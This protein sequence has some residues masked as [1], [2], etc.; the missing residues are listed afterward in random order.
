LEFNPNSIGFLNLSFSSDSIVF[1]IDYSDS[2][3]FS[4]QET[5]LF[6]V[7]DTDENGIRSSAIQSLVVSITNKLAYAGEDQTICADTTTLSAESI[8]GYTGSW[9]S[10]NGNP[11]FANSTFPNTKV[12]GLA[13]D[14]NTFIWTLRRNGQD[15]GK[16][17]VI[18]VNNSVVADAGEYLNTCKRDTNLRA[19]AL[20]TGE[21][22]RWT[23]LGS[24]NIAN[25]LSINTRVTNLAPF[26][27]I[28]RSNKFVWTVQKQNC[29]SRDTADVYFAE[30]VIT[31]ED[32]IAGYAGETINAKVTINDKYSLGDQLFID[33]PDS[34][35][36]P[37]KPI[38]DIKIDS[39]NN[40]VIFKTNP[41]KYV[42]ESDKTTIYYT[43]S[44][45]CG[46]NA[47]GK[48]VLNETT[49]EP[50]TTNTFKKVTESGFIYSFV[51]NFSEVDKNPNIKR[52]EIV[53]S[54]PA[55]KGLVN[56]RFSDDSTEALITVNYSSVPDFEGEDLFLLRVCDEDENG[57]ENCAIQ[58]FII[59]VKSKGTDI[60]IYNAL[61]PNGDGKH[62][63]LEIKNIHLYPDNRID[64]FNRWGDN[65]YSVEKYDNDKVKFDGGDLPDGTYYYVLEPGGDKKILK[66]FI[67][68]K[69]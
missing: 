62:D 29:V 21:I 56:T 14:T 23:S 26:D 18:I 54:N 38:L 40:I 36:G 57:T 69:K 46:S 35:K 68:L 7:W 50:P 33:V 47:L 6:R 20:K 28:N 41:R 10:L 8:S 5:F 43:L 19:I 32:V 66:G 15:I 2:P 59:L 39:I 60:E 52:I 30:V 27:S 16:D 67:L 63:F 17:T 11:K 1:D 31:V 3:F 34:S 49:N 13:Q 24:A 9:T 12:T 53:P 64:I 4:G 42:K 55:S 37:N 58:T 25:D 22:G 65:V 44:N 51:L 61:S 45:Q 48:I